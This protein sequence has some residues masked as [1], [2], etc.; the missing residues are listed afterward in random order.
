M[1]KPRAPRRAVF[2]DRDGTITEEVGYLNHLSRFHLFDFAG[3]AIHR[4]NEAG[5]PVIVV[6]NQSG[7]ARG[8]FP[9]SLVEEVHREM[10]RQ[11]ATDGAHVDGIYV[12]MHGPQDGCDCRKPKTGLLKQAAR[13]YNLDLKRSFV[14]GDR[15]ADVEMAHHAGA[16]GILVATGYGRGEL[17]WHGPSWPGQPD[18][19]AGDLSGAVDW[20]LRELR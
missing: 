14:V 3:Q 20:I 13:K 1:P 12:C 6:T 16:R 18:F 4:L 2:L 7:V 17:E 8:L 5:L 19:L 11:L 9:A 15:Y 10:T